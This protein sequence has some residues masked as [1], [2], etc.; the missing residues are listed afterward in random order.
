MQQEEP[1]ISVLI[2][3]Y[4]RT[5]YPRLSLDAT[6]ADPPMITARKLAVLMQH[7]EESFRDFLERANEVM[8]LFA[9]RNN[10]DFVELS[11]AEAV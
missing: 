1:R 6:Q 4:A 9:T 8:D 3:R 11:Y 2:F 7:D 5:I 10:C